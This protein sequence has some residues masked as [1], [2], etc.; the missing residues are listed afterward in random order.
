MVQS[1]K[2]FRVFVSSTFND[3][4]EERNI[5]QRNVFSKLR[6]LCMDQG[7]RF[8]AIDLRW[9]ISEEAGLDQK[10][11]KICLEEVDRCQILSPNLNFIVLLGDRRGWIPLPYEIPEEEF[12]EILTKITQ[13]DSRNLL[14]WN[15]NW[16][17]NEFSSYDKGWYRKDENAVPPVYCLKPRIVDFPENA[18]QEEIKNAKYKESDKWSDKENVLKNIILNAINELGWPKNDER[19]NKYENSATEQEIIKGILNPSKYIP[20]PEEHIFAFFRKIDNSDKISFNEHSKNFFDYNIDG[21]LNKSS[22]QK[23]EEIKDE[24]TDKLPSSNIFTYD[25]NWDGEKVSMNHLDE[26]CTNAYL[27]LEKIIQEQIDKYKEKNGLDIEIEAHKKFGLDR[28]KFFVGRKE[29]LEK[30]ND[31]IKNPNSSP[32]LVYGISGSG[33]STLIA[34]AIK[35]LNPKFYESEEYNGLI[36]RFI[37]VTPESSNRKSLLESI[38]HQIYRDFNLE[39]EKNKR[40]SEIKGND[41]ES[42]KKR[43]KISD[44]FLIPS[45]IYKLSET[46]K[47]FLTFIDQDKV[48]TIFIDALDQLSDSEYAHNLTWIPHKLPKNVHIILST[49][50]ESYNS[51][52]INKIPEDNLNEVS[53]LDEGKLLLYSWLDD[54]GR[55][56][57]EKQ[58]LEVL[59]KFKINGMPLYLKLAFEETKIWK[60]YSTIPSLNPKISGIIKQMF[61]RLSAPQN[62]GKV[63]VSRSLGY[64]FA[65]KNGLTEDEMLDILA[66]DEDVFSLTKK[67][68]EPIEKKLPVALWSRLYFD[69]EHYLTERNIDGISLLSFYHKQLGEVVNNEFLIDIKTERHKIL[70]EY[71]WNLDLKTG[72]TY[73]IRKVSELPYHEINGELWDKLVKTLCDLRFVDAKCAVGMTYNLVEDYNLALELHPDVQKEKQKKLEHEKLV[74]EYVRDSISYSKGEID[75]LNLISSIQPWT[76]EDIQRDIEHIIKNPTNLNKIKAFYQFVNSECHNLVNYSKYTNFSIQQAYNYAHNGPFAND[77]KQIIDE[78]IKEILILRKSQYRPKY[79]PYPPLIKMFDHGTG[80]RSVSITADCKKAVSGGVDGTLKVWNLEV[81]DFHVLNGHKKTICSVAIT[82]DGQIV[83]SADSDGKILVWNESGKCEKIKECNDMI[84]SIAITPNGE[85]VVYAKNDGTFSKWNLKTGDSENYNGKTNGIQSVDITPNNEIIVQGKEGNVNLWVLNPETMDYEEHETFKGHDETICSVK[86]TPDGKRIISGSYDASIGI[87]NL[88]DNKSKILK[89]HQITLRSVDIT[90]DGKI[91]I[92]GGDD[93]NLGIYD[94]N[95][96][97]FKTLK[98]H[99]KTISSVAVIPDGSKAI[100]GGDDKIMRLWDLEKCQPQTIHEHKDWVWDISVARDSNKAVSVGSDNKLIL[101]DLEKDHSQTIGTYE[102]GLLSVVITPNGKKAITGCS[103]GSVILWNLLNKSYKFLGNLIG[104][105]WDVEISPNG[106]KIVCGSSGGTRKFG[107]W[108]LEK[109]RSKI[110]DGPINSGIYDIVI[111]SDNKKAITGNDDGTLRIWDLN[112]GSFETL[113]DQISNFLAVDI[114]PNCKNVASGSIDGT[115]GIWDLKKGLI[116]TIKGHNNRIWSVKFINNDV[117]ISG[118]DDGTIR[119]WDVETSEQLAIYTESKPIISMELCPD[120]SIIIGNT[121]GE[122]Y[123]VDILNFNNNQL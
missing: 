12:E 89:K 43:K 65:A 24:I 51:Y 53:R 21:S 60:S 59:N 37:G 122:V 7:F 69:L 80:I 76:E 13:N 71:F 102:K 104:A 107:I 6:K 5:L 98:G 20:N 96:D 61:D 68:H 94:V 17:E 58:E 74:N 55:K 47:K 4:K 42:I 105:I 48:C 64:L 79:N 87:W 27:S 38:C 44:K 117:L 2:T 121:S 84:W 11:I 66:I 8:Q 111:T 93:R 34:E 86:I 108:D 31:Y 120:K 41:K 75:H 73:N 77:A 100:S 103:D 33:K 97:H 63:L 1:D 15:E 67:F 49:L 52:M 70:A 118:S 45:E 54:A 35:I 112:R 81:G 30:I 113:N 50:K 116:K 23:L 3:L 95:N 83:V 9:G 110:V 26:L 72:R 29:N 39:Y 32:F 19:R 14:V 40:L 46:F 56:L 18:S 91:T 16:P 62:H 99:T 123:K 88:E 115:L 22:K 36:V 10:T 90:P 85:K 109:K 57:T 92:S 78:G 106:K 25:A 28:S 114:T 82:P 101:W 119:L